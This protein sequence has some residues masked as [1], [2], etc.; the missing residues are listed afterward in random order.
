[1]KRRRPGSAPFLYEPPASG[2][3]Q[4][5][6]KPFWKWTR[7]RSRR[8]DRLDGPAEAARLLCPQ[9]CGLDTGHEL[10]VRVRLGEK[11][12]SR[13]QV[14]LPGPLAPRGDEDLHLGPVLVDMPGQFI[15]VHARRHLHVGEQHIHGDFGAQNAQSLRG[16]GRLDDTEI[17][18]QEN[19]GRHQ[20]H[21]R[22]V[23][24]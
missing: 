8:P 19:V 14:V 10:G 11:G 5:A 21:E 2:Y 23:F 9:G 16:V 6:L 7:R 1:M 3:G 18:L 24:D 15:A 4:G 12:R 13:R 17:R 20:P 22:F